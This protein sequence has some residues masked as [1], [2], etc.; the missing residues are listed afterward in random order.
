MTLRAKLEKLHQTGVSLDEAAVRFTDRAIS[1][2]YL[3]ARDEWIAAGSKIFPFPDVVFSNTPPEIAR[4][5]KIYSNYLVALRLVEKQL[6]ALLKSGVYVATAR[7]ESN[8]TEIYEVP[9]ANWEMLAIIDVSKGTARTASSPNTQH[10][11][12]RVRLAD[13]Q[14]V[15]DLAK[16]AKTPKSQRE[17]SEACKTFLVQMMSK[18]PNVPLRTKP[19]W[20]AEC[21]NRFGVSGNEFERIW[22]A[23]IKEAGADAWAHAGARKKSTRV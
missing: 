18:S 15:P 17:A 10:F 23:A 9:V 14:S 2:A 22:P 13:P 7:L 4:H 6:S 5:M 19:H 3:S 20:K 16:K 1:S 21:S 8:M 12:I 11:D